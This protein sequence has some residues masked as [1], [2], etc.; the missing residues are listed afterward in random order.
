MGALRILR[1]ILA[2][3]TPKI[4]TLHPAWGYHGLPNRAVFPQTFGGALHA[5]L[6][7]HYSQQSPTCSPYGSLH[8]PPER[9]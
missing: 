8:Y 6:A 1:G 3:P 9:M 5:E 7:V 2:A 4:R